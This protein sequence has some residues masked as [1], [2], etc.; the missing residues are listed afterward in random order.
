MDT[1]TDENERKWHI[2]KIL[3]IQIPK[4]LQSTICRPNLTVHDNCRAEAPEVHNWHQ[5]TC[6]R[7]VTE[8]DTPELKP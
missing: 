1:S 3:E 5:T 4:I 8:I 6:V 2:S 7:S